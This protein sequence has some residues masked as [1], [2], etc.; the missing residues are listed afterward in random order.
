MTL[1]L[2]LTP[3]LEER[4]TDEAERQGIPADEYAL[5]LLDKQLVSK[6]R[7]AEANGALIDRLLKHPLKVPNFTPLSRDEIYEQ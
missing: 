7:N 1:I 6:N 5:H 4:L 2:E 3:D